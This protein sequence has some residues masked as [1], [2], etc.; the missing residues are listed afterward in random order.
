MFV[1]HIAACLK[2][3]AGGGGG[4]KLNTLDKKKLKRQTEF[5]AVSEA[6]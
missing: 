2:K 4:L 3:I 1:S 6:H 5:S